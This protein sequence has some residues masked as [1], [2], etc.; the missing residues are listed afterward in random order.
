VATLA[1][2]AA[3]AA[4]KDPSHALELLEF[5]RGVIAS[6]L[7]DTRSDLTELSREAPDLAAKLEKIQEELDRLQSAATA[8]TD[9]RGP[10]FSVTR[11]HDSN[12]D[13]DKVLE[14]IR[15]NPIR[16]NPMFQ[17]FFL[18]PRAADLKAT[19]KDGVIVVINVNFRCDAIIVKDEKIQHVPLLDLTKKDILQA[20]RCMSFVRSK[21]RSYQMIELQR[22][23]LAW[24]WNAAVRPVLDAIGFVKTPKEGEWPRVWW[25]PTGALSQLPLY[26]AGIYE[27]GSSTTALD[28]VISSYS[29]SIKAL[30]YTKQNRAGRAEG[31][32]GKVI[33]AAMP[34]TPG[35]LALPFAKVEIKEIGSILSSSIPTEA[36]VQPSKENLVKMLE[37]CDVFHFAG[38]GK[39]DL[40]D[41][42][43]S[44]IYLQDCPLDV[45]ALVGLKLHKK[46]PW[47]AYLSACSTGESKDANLQDEA[48]HLVSACQLA[49]FQHVVGSFWE[50]P[51]NYS[52]KA[53]TQVYSTIKSGIG[54]SDDV[55]LGV[56]RAAHLLRGQNPVEVGHEVAKDDCEWPNK[57]DTSSV[58][59]D[60]RLS[61]HEWEEEADLEDML[62]G[63]GETGFLTG[64]REAGDLRDP[65]ERKRMVKQERITWQIGDPLVWAAY[66]HVGV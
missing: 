38:H 33:L 42:Y 55:A 60:P 9:S 41:P 61:K 5:G 46:A 16:G 34:T 44:C 66:F 51:D 47:L 10:N 57:H 37:S 30:R 49:G 2:A 21:P 14:K 13:L 45:K 65:G 20:V 40:R 23:L 48:I 17:T 26:A 18:P 25:V 19:V 12:E 59:A 6:F 35:Q 24:L 11:I 54:N 3:L 27:P 22:L 64:L 39:S 63:L 58:E 15:G 1:A 56:H 29:S 28:R 52:V 31:Q 62:L 50:V 53:A 8:T 43:L 32:T 36:L 7:L 4:G